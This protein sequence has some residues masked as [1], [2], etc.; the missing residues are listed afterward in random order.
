MRYRFNN[1]V[2]ARYEEYEKL[3]PKL[4]TDPETISMWGDHYWQ[5]IPRPVIDDLIETVQSYKSDEKDSIKAAWNWIAADFREAIAEKLSLENNIYIDNPEKEIGTCH[6]AADGFACVCGIFLKPGDEVL[7]LAP[8]FTFAWGLPDL[9]GAKTIPVP[10]REEN[11]W[12]WNEKEI[13]DLIEP[14][15]SEKTKMMISTIP[16]NPTGTV[17]SEG[18]TKA[19]GDILS[20]HKIIYLEDAVYERRLFDGYKFVSMASIPN[21]KEWAISLMGFSKIY[22]VQSFRVGYVV[23]NEEIIDKVWRWHMLGGIDPSAIFMKVCAKAY[24]RD[25]LGALPPQWHEE[26]RKEWDKVRKWT[27]D[28]ISTIPGIHLRMPHSGTYHFINISKL[29]TTDEIFTYLRDKHKV[30]LTPGTWYGPGGEGYVRL[31]YA[32]NLPERTMEGTQ[33]VAEALTK[34][35][36]EKG[37]AKTE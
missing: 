14:L 1:I 18:T 6:G 5:P 23:A 29:G 30:L 28:T 26:F 19:I 8:Q 25:M 21:M 11:D 36:K 27:Y 35:A 15:I 33:K 31:C 13:P 10:L 34:L 37:I 20:D 4:A 17:L 2:S 12:N 16:G 3:P 24:R 32:S 22:N 7:V 9:H